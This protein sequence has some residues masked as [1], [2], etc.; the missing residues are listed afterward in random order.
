MEK[1]ITMNHKTEILIAFGVGV[2]AGILLAPDSGEATRRKIANKAGD[3]LTA[4]KEKV[5]ERAEILR[6][7]T[8]SIKEAVQAARETYREELDKVRS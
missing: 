6:G 5:G 4:A 8:G 1:E 2:A 3:L 7:K